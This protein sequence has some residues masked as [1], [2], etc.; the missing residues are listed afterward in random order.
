MAKALQVG[1]VQPLAAIYQW[2]NMINLGSQRHTSS[3]GTVSTKRIGYTVRLADLLPL[4]IVATARRMGALRIV[5]LVP[6][7][8]SASHL[9]ALR[10]RAIGC[11]W[12]QTL[13]KFGFTQ[14]TGPVTL[15]RSGAASA[16]SNRLIPILTSH[17]A[18]RNSIRFESHPV[19]IT[20][21][22]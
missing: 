7:V 18:I 20:A 16:N 9:S 4:V 6:V 12:H 11:G 8:C 13:S 22:Q 14:R 15:T 10:A 3:L 19:E 17:E 1:P 5:A 2:D 21:R